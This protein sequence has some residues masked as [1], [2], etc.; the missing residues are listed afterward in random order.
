[1]VAVKKKRKSVL[2]RVL[3]LAF[4]V[5]ILVSLIRFQ[6]QLTESRQ[7]LAEKTAELEAKNLEISELEQ[8][9]DSGTEAQ[10]VERAA[11]ERLGY[12]YPDEQVHIDLS[13]Q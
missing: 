7:Q 13:G 11:R 10:L 1:M 5:Y 8:L 2:L 4:S 3:L 9:L 6:L 12:V